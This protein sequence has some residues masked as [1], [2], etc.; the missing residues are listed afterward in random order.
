MTDEASAYFSEIYERYANTV[1]RIGLV[2]LKNKSDAE[3]VVSDLFVKLM[4]KRPSFKSSEHERAYIIRSAVNL[5]KDRLKSPRF[6]SRPLESW[7][8]EY[9][10]GGE[11]I[12]LMEE[13][14]AMP[15]K[16]RSVIYL[17]CCA[18]YSTE[19]IG[20]M[21]KIRAGTVRSLLSRGRVMLKKRL[22]E[23]GFNDV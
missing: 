6:H 8:E 15:V 21:L 20:S 11:E 10:S 4:E 1:L 17:H 18:G 13:L 19:E 22:N 2:W 9:F 14:M 3:D 5:C 12:G 23:G 7:A 16:Y